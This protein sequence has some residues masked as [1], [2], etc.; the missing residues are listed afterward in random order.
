M[1]E[2]IKSHL[3]MLK[4]FILSKKWIVYKVNEKVQQHRTV[5]LKGSC[6]FTRVKLTKNPNVKK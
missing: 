3:P 5:T 2:Q 4:Q 1:S 6:Q